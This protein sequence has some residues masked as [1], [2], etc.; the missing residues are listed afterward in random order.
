MKKYTFLFL[1]P[2]LMAFTCED[3]NNYIVTDI[4]LL[5]KWILTAQL[6]DPGD[7]SGTFQP[8]TSNLTLDFLSNGIV[9]I[10]YGSFCSFNIQSEDSGTGNYDINTNTINP[11]CAPEISIEYEIERG[12]LILYFSCIE[13]CAEKY[14]K[15]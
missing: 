6:L 5:G 7:G 14:K 13:A 1:F 2:F 8:V 9:H 10:T 11:F 3:D 15:L 4:E 12:D